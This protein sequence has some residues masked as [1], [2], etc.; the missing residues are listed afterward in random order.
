MNM[1]DYTKAIEHMRN[2]EN[3]RRETQKAAV[4]TAENKA[5][6][7]W[8]TA[9]NRIIPIQDLDDTHILNIIS[10]LIKRQE[11]FLKI[12]GLAAVRG[13]IIARPLFREK[14]VEFW[15][16][17]LLIELD[18]RAKEQTEKAKELVKLAKQNLENIKNSLKD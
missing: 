13:L 16:D 10:Y 18:N 12:K 6:I 4:A 9:N 5:H 15:L 7:F 3:A 2:V 14:P 11:E 17:T 8:T 1:L